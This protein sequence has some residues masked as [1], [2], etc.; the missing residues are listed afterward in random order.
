M[1]D[2][3]CHDHAGAG[4]RVV[5]Y[6]DFA[7]SDSNTHRRYD[8]VVNL[9]A[10]VGVFTL[11]AQGCRDGIRGPFELRQQCVATQ[12]S[13]SAVVTPDTNGEAFE[14]GPDARVRQL[15][16]L[17]NERCRSGDVGVHDDR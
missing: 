12:L 8:I 3:L 6:D 11:G 1:F 10:S 5:R 9:A 7:H 17:L 4:N 14:G 15:F 2:S 13:D 16:V